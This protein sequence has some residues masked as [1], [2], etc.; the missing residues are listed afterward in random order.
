MRSPDEVSVMNSPVP[1]SCVAT[2]VSAGS[3]VRC[4]SSRLL[5]EMLEGLRDRRQCF[6]EGW[7]DFTGEPVGADWC[8]GAG[9]EE[10]FG[11]FFVAEAWAG[12]VE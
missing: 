2:D 5:M 9:E 3:P 11:G 10:L 6:S 1:P 4:R 8:D 12:Q 7:F